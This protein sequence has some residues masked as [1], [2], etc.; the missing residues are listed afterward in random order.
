MKKFTKYILFISLGLLCSCS[1]YLD[2]VPDNVTTLDIVFNNKNTAQRY[3]A[4]CYHFVPD[5]GSV[6]R[7]PGMGAG[8]ECWFYTDKDSYF[9]NEVSFYIA[10]GLQNTNAPYANYWDGEGGSKL[11][12]FRAIRECN[13]FLS[14]V[15]DQH[16]VNDLTDS[17]RKRWI[18]E[19]NVLKAY[20]HFFLFEHYGPIPIVDEALPVST[21][22]EGVKVTRMPVDQ[23]V[24][25]MVKLIDDSY[26]DLPPVITMEAT[27]MGRLTQPAALAL[28]AKIL[29]WAASP[30]FNGNKEYANFRNKEGKPLINQEFSREKW[31]KTAEACKAAIESAEANGCK[32]YDC[33]M[34]MSYSQ[35]LPEEIFYS[36]NIRQTV[37]E[38]FNPE[39]IWSVGKQG[40]N[41]LQNL[42]MA[43]IVPS[44]QQGSGNGQ[45]TGSILQS[46]AAGVY[47][48]T[49]ETAEQFYS[50]NGVPIDEDKEWLTNGNYDNRYTT[51]QV[52]SA[53]KYNMRTGWTTAVLHFNRE[54]RFYGS[55]GFDG[56]TWY[57]NGRTDVNDLNY[58]D[59]KYGR[60]S[61]NKWGFNYSITG[62]FAKKVVYY[63]NAITQSSQVV[64]E[65]PFPIIRLGD[66]YLMYA[67]SLNEATEGDNNVPEEVYTYLRK[68]RE[69]SGLK[70]GVL[71]QTEDIGD[72]RVAWE[73]Y[74]NDPTKP[75]TKD[76]M[77]SIIKQ[78]RKIELA[79]EGHQ[80]NDLRRWKD[81]SK[82]LSKSIKGW[83]VQG[84]IEEDFYK[85]TTLFVPRAFTTKDYLWPIKK[86]DLQVDDKLIQTYRW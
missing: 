20:Y 35:D 66:L 71:G 77:R 85:V 44:L 62:Y 24:D 46:R 8:H 43:C 23:V 84:E 48:P 21:S 57:G 25:F 15:R 27:E 75:K 2:I 59:G 17:E 22:S 49:L 50:K 52:T 60:N 42:S 13:I 28:K 56:S 14:Y 38:R 79:L 67:E 83:N 12:M 55:L 4:N 76:G 34:D 72:V 41:E 40:T 33:S 1:D 63:Q 51:R 9:D 39:L 80:Y 64:Y 18:A 86:Q 61:G 53:D 47:A 16:K 68:V 6:K 73:K 30:L 65:Y 36:M 37:T 5:H 69:R 26:K 31:V 70:K 32:L 3:L 54:P 82:E 45:V 74:S 81:A 10:R 78:E 58:V 7:I 19:V 11:P 29:L